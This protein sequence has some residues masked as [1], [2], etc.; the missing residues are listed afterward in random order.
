MESSGS[1]IYDLTHR[2]KEDCKFI[3]STLENAAETIDLVRAALVRNH[4]RFE[5]MLDMLQKAAD[6]L[7]V[8]PQ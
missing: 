1:Q 3:A 6:E 7:A 4:E 8:E 2:I 5:L